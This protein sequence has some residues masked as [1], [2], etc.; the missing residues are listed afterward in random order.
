[1]VFDPFKFKIFIFLSIFAPY[2]NFK[3]FKAALALFRCQYFS[4]HCY[5]HNK[6]CKINKKIFIL[7]FVSRFA[8][9]RVNFLF[10]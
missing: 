6:I 1:M 9:K 10:F 8:F 3:K 5:M 2:L 4:S 7:T